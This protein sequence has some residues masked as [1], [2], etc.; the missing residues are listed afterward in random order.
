MY[1]LGM[2]LLVN[3]YVY[4]YRAALLWNRLPADVRSKFTDMSLNE[5]KNLYVLKL[6]CMIFC[7]CQIDFCKHIVY[8]VKSCTFIWKSGPL[9]RPILFCI[10]RVFP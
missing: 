9:G 8:N 10:E 1:H 6:I 4:Q 5:V 3:V 7:V 2:L